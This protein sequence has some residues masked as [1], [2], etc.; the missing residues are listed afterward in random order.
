MTLPFE[1]EKW[2]AIN[3]ART[4]RERA[5]A[6]VTAAPRVTASKR[7]R[8]STAPR[9]S[10]KRSKGFMPPRYPRKDVDYPAATRP[11]LAPTQ[12]PSRTTTAR[13][14]FADRK[15]AVH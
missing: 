13:G 4:V 15:T 9:Y 7:I 14:A 5:A 3:T 10:D 2:L 8:R 6:A 1:N 12:L 11:L